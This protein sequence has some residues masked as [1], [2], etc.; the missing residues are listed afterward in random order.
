MGRSK[1]TT[2]SGQIRVKLNGSLS[3]E[4]Q[5]HSGSDSVI[6]EMNGHKLQANVELLKFKGEGS[7]IS[8]YQLSE[9][10]DFYSDALERHYDLRKIY[11]DD[12]YPGVT[13]STGYG[14][15]SFNK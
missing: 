4:L 7:L 3:Y 9:I 15:I 10:E 14:V 6:F 5:A 12:N 2:G 13:L 11:L 1:L 8:D